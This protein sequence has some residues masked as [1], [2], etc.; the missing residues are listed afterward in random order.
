MQVNSID[1]NTKFN[2]YIDNS[3]VKYVNK[4]VQA[5][6]YGLALSYAEKN[7]PVNM[8]QIKA[9]R[10]LGADILETLS[11]YMETLETKTGLFVTKR[12]NPTSKGKYSKEL[13]LELR[14][15]VTKQPVD[16]ATSTNNIVGNSSQ[17]PLYYGIFRKFDINFSEKA[18]DEMKKITTWFT[19]KSAK[20]YDEQIL[21]NA[22]RDLTLSD[23]TVK[24]FLSRRRLLNQAQ[25]V[26]FYMTSVGAEH[27]PKTKRLNAESVIEGIR[28]FFDG[29]RA[30]KK[31]EI[32]NKRVVRDLLKGEKS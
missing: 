3:V 15:P 5:R 22:V 26:E 21:D 6:C 30:R 1:N 4:A 14:N 27:F 9:F 20:F 7:E 11:E 24:N 25:K 19:N 28:D 18:L 2:G 23:K 31:Q 12:L 16:I 10:Q 13:V 29:A 8:E 17:K 32:V